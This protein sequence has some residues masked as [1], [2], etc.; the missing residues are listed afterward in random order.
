MSSALFCTSFQTFKDYPQLKMEMLC[1][2]I[3]FTY[4][5]EKLSQMR[6]YKSRCHKTNNCSSTAMQMTRGR[7]VWLLLILDLGT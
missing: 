2:L 4:L 1:H 5:E 7:G 6:N 3:L